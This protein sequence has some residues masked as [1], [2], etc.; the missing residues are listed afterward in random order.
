VVWLGKE[1]RPASVMLAFDEDSKEYYLEIEE[2]I[3]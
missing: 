2:M 1:E 3:K